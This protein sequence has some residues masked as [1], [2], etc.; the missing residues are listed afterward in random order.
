MG[1]GKT[2]ARKSGKTG[3]FRSI[4]KSVYAFGKRFAD[5]SIGTKFS[6]VIF[7]AGNLFHGQVIKGL[8]FLLVQVVESVPDHI[9]IGAVH[10]L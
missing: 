2:R 5:G 8:L 6:H 3:F 7:G 4:G 1:T 10:V 9:V